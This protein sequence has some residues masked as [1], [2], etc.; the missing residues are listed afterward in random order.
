[1][2]EKLLKNAHFTQSAA[3]LEQTPADSTCEVAFSGRSN[4][5][6]SSVIN[7]LTQQKKLAR[8]SKTP[9]RTQLLNYFAIDTG[10]YIVDLPGYGFAKVNI[11]QQQKWQKVLTD[12]FYQKESLKS[13]VLIMDIRHPLKASDIEMLN[14]AID[15]DKKILILLNKADKLSKNQQQKQLQQVKKQVHEAEDEQ[16][17][18][19]I[20]STSKGI[21]KQKV[22]AILED[23]FAD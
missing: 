15:A 22:Y 9:G 1:M 21:N 6:K 3:L 13:V 23:F 16:M 4:S 12:Y 7:C 19:E 17:F 2:I 11:K 8:T 18:V 5:G 20:F 10:K 14:L